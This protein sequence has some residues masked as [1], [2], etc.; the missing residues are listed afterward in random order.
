MDYVLVLGHRFNSRLF[1]RISINTKM[2]NKAAYRLRS[3]KEYNYGREIMES[4]I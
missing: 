3:W 1:F 2:K 4:V